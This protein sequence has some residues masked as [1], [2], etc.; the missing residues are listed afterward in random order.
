MQ[1]AASAYIFHCE[2]DMFLSCVGFWRNGRVTGLLCL[3][4]VT[5]TFKSCKNQVKMINKNLD[6]FVS[7][8]VDIIGSDETRRD[9]Y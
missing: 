2:I 8:K 1:N 5:L 7:L 3:N 6:D 9:T 4:A